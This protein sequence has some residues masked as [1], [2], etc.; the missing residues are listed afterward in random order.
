MKEIAI[1]LPCYNENTT[2]IRFLEILEE[3]IK[4]LPHN[5]RVIV[6]D[7]AST[8]NTLVLLQQ[9]SFQNPAIQI[10]ILS[11]KFNIGHQ[12]AIYQ[13]FLYAQSLTNNTFIIM[14]S[15]GEDDPKAI[16]ILLEKAPN[17][18]I[19]NVVRGKRRESLSFILFYQVYK[20]IFKFITGTTI[21]YGNYSLITKKILEK[22][23]FHQFNHFPAFLSKQKCS[24]TTIMVDRMKRISG[25]SK[26]RFSNL[27][28]HAFYS[29]VE[30]AESI[31]LVFFKLF[32]FLVLLFFIAIGNVLYQKFIANTAI[33]GW[34]STIAISLMNTALI[35]IGFFVMGILSLNLQKK[36]SEDKKTKIYEKIN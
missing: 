26:M 29:F 3:A 16:K 32:I 17:H 31:L 7:D 2:I 10:D 14:D 25:K 35:S 15:D 27:L 34:S 1:L 36:N 6:I 24:K 4:D 20:L 18:Q 21:N 13:G 33:L 23:I 30:Y 12:G 8:D 22:A 28:Y 11:L 5:F 9:F 19:I